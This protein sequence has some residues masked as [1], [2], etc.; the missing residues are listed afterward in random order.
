[1]S[2]KFPIS[3][4]ILGLLR[5]YRFVLTLIITVFLSLLPS[6]W[7][8]ARA[9]GIFTSA[10]NAMNCIIKSAGSGAGATNTLIASLPNVI[11][12]A[13]TL[14][15]FAYFLG[16]IFHLVQAVKAGEEVSQ[17]VIPILA[18]II[19]VIV[20]TVFQNILFG[21]GGGC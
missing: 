6:L 8:R 4:R 2:A 19:G 18:A 7:N 20:I 3:S 13:I 10:K 21:A 11:F 12:T 14:F 17:L 9:D 16:S 15:L 1:M 5:Q